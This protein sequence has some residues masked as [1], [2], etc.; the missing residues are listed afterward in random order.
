MKLIIVLLSSYYGLLVFKLNAQER[1]TSS[2]ADI[3]KSKNF[4]RL[5]SNKS[6]L[7][8]VTI[9]LCVDSSI[10]LVP[11]ISMCAS[12]I[13]RLDWLY[14]TLSVLLVLL[15]PLELYIHNILTFDIE[16]L[17]LNMYQGRSYEVY[18]T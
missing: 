1:H 5:E 13:V 3:L 12:A 14:Q 4:N 2:S 16:Y 11:S 9:L 7:H 10:L 6:I 15:T 17:R 8:I 18:S